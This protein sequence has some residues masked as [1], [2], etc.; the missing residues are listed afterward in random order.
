MKEYPLLA[1]V[2]NNKA[3]PAELDHELDLQ[4]EQFTRHLILSLDPVSHVSFI[5]HHFDL[6]SL[7]Q[8]KL[9]EEKHIC[10]FCTS[11]HEE[12]LRKIHGNMAVQLSDF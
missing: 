9:K 7:H 1:H 8:S 10:I 12:Y 3:L 2:V 6:A 11:T 5:F 4:L